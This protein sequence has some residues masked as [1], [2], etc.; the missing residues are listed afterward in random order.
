MKIG[1]KIE[2]GKER[3]RG[4]GSQ[5]FGVAEWWE[6]VMHSLNEK[7]NK[8]NKTDTGSGVCVDYIEIYRCK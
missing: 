7:S 2:I 1:S 5:N 3:E 8:K 4:G 6:L